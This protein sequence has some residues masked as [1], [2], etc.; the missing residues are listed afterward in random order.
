MRLDRERR[1]AYIRRAFAKPVPM[2][3]GYLQNHGAKAQRFQALRWGI[4]QRQ[5]IG[6]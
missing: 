2:V 3:L 6:L 1:T 4:V 5:N